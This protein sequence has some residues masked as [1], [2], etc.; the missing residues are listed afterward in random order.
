MEPGVIVADDDMEAMEDPVIE[1]D[2]S[3]DEDEDGNVSEMDSDHD[4]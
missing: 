3:E 4:E 2:E 1:K